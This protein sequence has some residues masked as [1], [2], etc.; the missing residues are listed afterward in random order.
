M[1]RRRKSLRDFRS[2]GTITSIEAPRRSRSFPGP[3]DH[4]RT[5]TQ[6]DVEELRRTVGGDAS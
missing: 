4:T 5:W 3:H 1:K 6:E 2:F